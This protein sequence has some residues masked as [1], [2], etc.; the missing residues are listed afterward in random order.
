MTSS[1]VLTDGLSVLGI[2]GRKLFRTIGSYACS[3]NVKVYISY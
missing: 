2:E 3:N 1:A